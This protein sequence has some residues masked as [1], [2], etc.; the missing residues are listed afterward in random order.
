MNKSKKL[1]C[2]TN[3]KLLK[4]YLLFKINAQTNVITVLTEFIPQNSGEVGACL[5]VHKL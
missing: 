3:I 2:K 4:I 5:R 1:F